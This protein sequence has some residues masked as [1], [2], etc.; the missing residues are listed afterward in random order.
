MLG[1]AVL[2]A[3]LLGK[4]TVHRDEK[5]IWL[6][7]LV[8]PWSKVNRWGKRVLSNQ[9]YKSLVDFALYL[10]KCINWNVIFTYSKASHRAT[11]FVRACIHVKPL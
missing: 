8:P 10:M 5:G 11:K 2:P 1:E 4:E 3:K 7:Q 9:Y 6:V